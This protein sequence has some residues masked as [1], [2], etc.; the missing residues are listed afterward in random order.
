MSEQLAA[1]VALPTRLTG[2]LAGRAVRTAG[3]WADDV[4]DWGRDEGLVNRLWWTSRLRWDVTVGGVSNLMVRGGG[5]IVVNARR[6]ALAPVF[7]ALALT[8]AVQRP[9][10]F[11]GRPDIAPFGPAL[12]RLGGLLPVPDEVE[13]A[14]RAGELVVL[15]AAHESSNRRCGRID[16]HLVGAAVTAKVPVFPGA[17]TSSLTGRGARVEIGTP[18]RLPRRRRGPLAD[19]ELAR[20][21]RQRIDHILEAL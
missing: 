17:T 5:L 9:V 15:G 11:I 4:D 19:V 20:A 13:G 12:Q 14:L 21:A 8:D 16:H 18:V 2:D 3:L 6:Y 1:V 7:A 10:R